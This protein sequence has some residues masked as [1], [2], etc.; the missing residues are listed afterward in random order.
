MVKNSDGSSAAAL[1]CCNHSISPWLHTKSALRHSTF[2]AILVVVC[3]QLVIAQH[4]VCLSNLQSYEPRHS[5]DMASAA[6]SA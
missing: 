6:G 3:A 2:L 4:L 5:R 1:A